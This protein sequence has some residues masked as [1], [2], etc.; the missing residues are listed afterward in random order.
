VWLNLPK[1]IL[2]ILSVL[3]VPAVPNKNSAIS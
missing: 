1:I 2:N 3:Y